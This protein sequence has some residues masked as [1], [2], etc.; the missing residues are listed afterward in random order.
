MGA[1]F[2]AWAG[3][4]LYSFIA[5]RGDVLLAEPAAVDAASKTT[6]HQ[7]LLSEPPNGMVL[8]DRTLVP[9]SSM[10]LGVEATFS[11]ETGARTIQVLSGGYMDELTESYD[12]LRV[13][14][15]A[16]VDGRAATVLSGSLLTLDVQLASWRN[17]DATPPCDMYAAIATNVTP[18]DFAQALASI[19]TDPAT[20]QN[21]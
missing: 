18:T 2:V 19:T 3:M 6:C 11:D 17:V 16:T 7:A 5:T 4:S 12:D 9:Y 14:A 8:T 10:L 1:V 13:T 21:D 20:E 15:Q